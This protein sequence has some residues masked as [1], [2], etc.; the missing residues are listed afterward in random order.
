MKISKKQLFG[1]IGSLIGSMHGGGMTGRVFNLI[2]KE[3]GDRLDKKDNI[4]YVKPAK[5]K[6]EKIPK[7]AKEAKES[8]VIHKHKYINNKGE[9]HVHKNKKIEITQIKEKQINV[10]KK[11]IDLVKHFS[12]NQNSFISYGSVIKELYGICKIDGKLLC[13]TEIR[14]KLEAREEQK[15]TKSQELKSVK[16]INQKTFFTDVAISI[17]AGEIH[18]IHRIW[19]DDE[20]VDLAQENLKFR[21]Y[22][23]SEDQEP[24]SALSAFYK[25]NTTAFRGLCY[26]VIEDF[27]LS[28]YGNIPDFSFEVLKKPNIISDHSVENMVKS[29]VIIP[30]SGEFVYDTKVQEKEYLANAENNII[31]NKKINSHNFK[32][33][34]NSIYS[35]D[36]LQFVCPKID[37]VSVVV[38]WFG[39]SLNIANCDILPYVENE[40]DNTRY[41]EDWRSG[42][43]TRE[44]A[45]IISKDSFGNPNYGGTV[46]DQS[47][48]RYVREIKDRGLKVLLYPMFLLDIEGKPWR[49]H[50]TGNYSDV[51]NFFNKET[52]YNK[53]IT[54]YARLLGNDID[55][56]VI[57]SELKGITKIKNDNNN[58]NNNLFPSVLELKKL[59]TN[60]KNICPNTLISYAADWS[61]YHHTDGGWRHLDTLWMDQNIDFIGIDAYFPLTNSLNS[62]I[63][64]DDIKHGWESGECYDYYLDGNQKRELSADWALKN[65]KHWWENY[66]YNPNGTRTEWLPRAKK[67]WF[68]E[69]G[70]PSIDKSTN[71]PNVF[72]NPNCSDG[73]APTNSS[74]EI[75][76]KIQREAIRATLEYFKDSQM[77][78]KM[79]LWCWDARP[80][81]IWPHSKIW[82]DGNLWSRGHWVNG[83]FSNFTLGD[84]ILDVCIKSG[85][86]KEC[87]DVSDLDEPLYGFLLEKDLTGSELINLLRCS[88]FFDIVH[89]EN[90]IR[91]TKRGKKS[92][93]CI[94]KENLLQL[95]NL[96]YIESE[97]LSDKDLLSQSYIKFLDIAYDYEYK[98]KFSNLS[99]SPNNKIKGFCMPI[100]MESSVAKNLANVILKNSRSE[101]CIFRFITTQIFKNIIPSDVI[102]IEIEYSKFL[103]RVTEIS[104]LSNY[105]M[106]IT[107]VLEDLSVYKIKTIE[108]DSSHYLLSGESTAAEEE[109]ESSEIDLC[110][111]DAP[112][113]PFLPNTSIAYNYLYVAF[114]SQNNVQ[115]LLSSSDQTEYFDK[116]ILLDKNTAIGKVLSFENK[117]FVSHFFEDRK[118]HFLIQTKANL[119]V[120]E[121]D[122]IYSGS[123]ALVGRE[124]ITFSKTELLS[125]ENCFN[126]YKIS[127]FTRGCFISEKYINNHKIGENFVLLEN[128]TAISLRKSVRNIYYK[129]FSTAKKINISD[130]PKKLATPILRDFAINRN[131]II[132]RWFDRPRGI[133]E[134]DLDCC[135]N[136]SKKFIIQIHK[137]QN[138]IREEIIR[139]ENDKKLVFKKTINLGP[140]TFIDSSYFLKIDK[141]DLELED[142]SAKFLVSIISFTED[143]IKSEPLVFEFNLKN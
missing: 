140:S 108:T 143:C 44:N 31:V 91:F 84:L 21:L 141:Y 43:Y 62:D 23:G 96:A 110:F 70:F 19:I 109:Y 61:E 26:I 3:L 45:K 25:E 46:N 114:S 30:G 22:K 125:S 34:P 93:I 76:N 35:L 27:P 5:E 58:D 113:L 75:D 20:I 53:F 101:N 32:K 98:T 118:S 36:N 89:D 48:I 95:K 83:K 74:S 124:V 56:L 120:G 136:D 126:V 77:I 100:V 82:S 6:K 69:F 55:A 16:T 130:Y 39:N 24:D 129:I 116:R 49:G 51:E 13:I 17:C 122:C 66:H 128:I 111:L 71:K 52:G 33:I 135:A 94:K 103:V 105:Q 14:E 92:S 57:G 104:L 97:F 4:K 50:V 80:Y 37:Y 123:Y 81:P 12:V 2:G 121:K 115:M 38:C 106:I 9:K 72:Y 85:I 40:V 29:M 127:L 65:I 87:V 8:V 79:F 112:F 41:S 88:Y 67:I 1:K 86:T 54:H 132:I 117:G 119:E 73:G 139:E 60:I 133:D 18:D 42:G 102:E 63:S 15:F 78:E 47:L 59:A 142:I 28:F 99:Y 10:T 11:E 137:K 138:T 7:E 107:C 64:I 131:N 68:T 134:W 90:K